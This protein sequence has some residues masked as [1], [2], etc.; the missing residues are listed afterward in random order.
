MRR[1]LKP[2]AATILIDP[3]NRPVFK[4]LRF[5]MR[6][7]NF[8]CVKNIFVMARIASKVPNRFIFYNID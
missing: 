6:A 4:F 1:T 5:Y 3:Q 7:D 2:P 8:Q